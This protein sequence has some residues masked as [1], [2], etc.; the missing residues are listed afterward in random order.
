MKKTSFLLCANSLMKLT[1]SAVAVFL[2]LISTRGKFSNGQKFQNGFLTRERER[3]RERGRD[4]VYFSLTVYG[5]ILFPECSLSS[6][7]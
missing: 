1:L 5:K 7:T 2:L 6:H 3:E 4:F